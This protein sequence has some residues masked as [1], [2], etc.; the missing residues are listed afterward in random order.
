MRKEKITVRLPSELL[1]RLT[2]IS[3]RD[4]VSISELVR[5]ALEQYIP[6]EIAVFPREKIILRLPP[7]RLDKLQMLVSSGDSYTVQEAIDAALRD[8]IAR[9]PRAMIEE[10]ERLR[11]ICEERGLIEAGRE[12]VKERLKK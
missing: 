11:V 6:S 8:Y 9:R 12:R 7:D 10:N 1:D 5:E 4:K 2:E 3:Q